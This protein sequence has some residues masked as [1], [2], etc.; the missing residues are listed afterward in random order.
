MT[1]PN[2]Y[3]FDFYGVLL[4]QDAP[5]QLK[6]VFRAVGEPEKET[7]LQEIYEELRPDLDAGRVSEINYWN[8][9]KLRAQL[10]FLDPQEAI[11]A[12]Y[13]GL[14][15]ADPEM[16]NFALSL[17]QAGHHIGV[18]S[19]IPK[20]LAQ[21]VKHHNQSWL[22]QLDALVF[23][24]DIGAAKPELP[25]FHAAQEALGVPASEIVFIDDRLENVEAAREAGM[26]AFVFTSLAQ[27][28]KDLEHE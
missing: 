25:A 10:E 17:K 4:K 23:S 2:T 8:Q 9:I 19:N 24:C 22:D 16:V 15:E 21:I 18:L 1:K 13:A 20:G 12:D 6:R 7:K 5:G 14:E 11:S 3:L 26:Q 27:L 28:K